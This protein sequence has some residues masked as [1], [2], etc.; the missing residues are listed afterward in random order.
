M[1]LG[2]WNRTSPST[3]VRVKV[4][5][6]AIG[7]LFGAQACGTA[8]PPPQ[9]KPKAPWDEGPA[10]HMEWSKPA[11]LSRGGM[12]QPCKEDG[13]C[14]GELSC[15]AYR[16][17][18]PDRSSC[19]KRCSGGDAA[20]CTALGRLHEKA[21]DGPGSWAE[22]AS[23]YT[24][25]CDGK[26]QGGCAAL[27]WLLFKGKGVAEDRAKAEKLA[28]TA[29]DLGDV[30]GCGLLGHVLFTP[31]EEPRDVDRARV[32]FARSCGISAYGCYRYAK[33]WSSGTGKGGADSL[34]AKG[35]HAKACKLGFVSS[36]FEPCRETPEACMTRSKESETKRPDAARRNYDVL[37]AGLNPHAEACY[38]L[39]RMYQLGI[40]MPPDLDKATYEMS[41]GCK[42]KHALACV[43][44]AKLDDDPRRLVIVNRALN[45][46]CSD[47][48]HHGCYALGLRLLEG[49]HMPKDAAQAAKHL[50]TACDHDVAES[51]VKL[52]EQY[53]TGTGVDKNA[54]QA[55]KLR[56]RACELGHEPACA[57]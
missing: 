51:C 20:A 10:P 4:T 11:D 23:A 35:Y 55:K 36:C 57:K 43:E 14:D 44:W 16:C 53:D 7:V 40:G 15:L 2:E 48:A 39:G 30:E 27:G 24:K 46:A 19:E 21:I 25:A 18:C 8:P 49:K 50:Q 29:C 31:D 45:A 1:G 28:T 13:S 34:R 56:A 54:A 17:S 9:P 37:C 5:L 47:E 52:A 32:V 26:H 22:A 12:A 33:H 41:N 3:P 38:R 6:A 42:A